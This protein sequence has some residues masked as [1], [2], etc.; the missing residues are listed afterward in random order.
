MPI[1]AGPSANTQTRR[2]V[3]L[4]WRVAVPERRHLWVGT[5]WLLAAAL[6]EALVPLLGKHFIDDYLLPRKLVLAEVASLLVGM[7]T[8]G[9]VASVL[10]YAQLVRLAGVAMRSVQRLRQEVFA[11]VVRLPM[12]YFDKAIT[13]QLVSRVTNDTE[14]VKS[15]YV[16]V[17]FV[18]LDSGI[19]VDR[20]SVV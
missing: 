11:H 1:D 14:Q 6:L 9:C 17:L 15:L 18:M 8:A 13:G 2:A 12:A 19:V 4:L 20:K 10:R 16:Q 7:L 5:F 3:R